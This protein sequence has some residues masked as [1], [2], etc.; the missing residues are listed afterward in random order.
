MGGSLD[1][2]AELSVDTAQRLVRAAVQAPS[3]RERVALR[4][5]L[6]RVLAQDLLVANDIPPFDTAAMDGY[7][8]AAAELDAGGNADLRLAGS[9]LAGHRHVG[10]VPPGCCLRIMTGAP[11]PAGCDTVVP[12]EQCIDDGVRVMLRGA[13]PGAHC[14]K[15]GEDLA[16]GAVALGAGSRLG[17]AELGLAAAMGCR[18]LRVWRRPRVALLSSGDELRAPGQA[19]GDDGIYDSNR[20]I[21][22]ALATRCGAEVVDLGCVPD[23]VDALRDALLQASA[24]ADLV[25]TSGGVGGGDADHLRAACADLGDVAFWQLAMRPGRP[26]AFGRIGQ[27]PRAALLFGLP[28]NPVALM[29]AFYVMVRDALLRLGGAQPREL[30]RLRA[31]AQTPLRKR[32]GRVEFQRARIARLANGGWGAWS[33]GAQ[34]SAQLRSMIDADGLLVLP[35][36]QG[37]LRIGDPVEFIAFE[38]LA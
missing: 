17:A 5:A 35:A 20:E 36:A 24:D 4:A 19:L 25:L 3:R 38:G 26:L 14:R 37:D 30:P 8:C 6:G 9:A 34:G 32:A 31:L 18:E 13:R 2:R 21:L 15:R 7:A 12:H 27:G 10:S 29:V 23:R 33:T 16:C 22:A 28:G 1:A 11:L